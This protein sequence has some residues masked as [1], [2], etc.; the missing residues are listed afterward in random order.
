MSVTL[1][2]QRHCGTLQIKFL[3]SG[4]YSSNVIQS[5]LFIQCNTES[6]C[7]H[8]TGSINIYLHRCVSPLVPVCA[9]YLC[10]SVCDIKSEF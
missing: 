8:I 10:L 1:E 7:E 4:N 5:K 3:I 6:F 2:Q 9:M